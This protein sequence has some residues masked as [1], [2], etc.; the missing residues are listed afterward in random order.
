MAN[1]RLFLIALQV[2]FKKL[3]AIEPDL[4]VVIMAY[5]LDKFQ[6]CRLFVEASLTN[7]FSET[8]Q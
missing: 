4:V 5:A 7:L 6:N 8:N 3:C 2:V 1:Y